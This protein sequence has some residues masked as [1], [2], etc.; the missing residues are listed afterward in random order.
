MEISY[1]KPST[2]YQNALRASRVNDCI[3]G[4]TRVTR[5]HPMMRNFSKTKKLTP[6]LMSVLQK[7][8]IRFCKRLGLLVLCTGRKNKFRQQSLPLVLFF[9]CFFFFWGGGGVSPLQGPTPMVLHELIIS[10]AAAI[11]IYIYHR[12]TANKRRQV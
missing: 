5:N 11:Y 10:L 12:N 3:K 8:S 6:C 2:F 7:T 9:S 4:D 1:E